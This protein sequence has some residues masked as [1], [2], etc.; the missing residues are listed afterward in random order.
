[1]W[2]LHTAIP[3]LREVEWDKE[4]K[5]Q[6]KKHPLSLKYLLK[7]YDLSYKPSKTKAMIVYSKGNF[8]HHRKQTDKKTTYYINLSLVTEVVGD[9]QNDIDGYV[10]E[11]LAYGFFDK[12]IRK[13]LK[14]DHKSK[15]LFR[16]NENTCIHDHVALKQYEKVF[17]DRA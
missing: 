11:L 15:V 12:C 16:P 10:V 17:S 9:K 4:I 3:D 7:K 8:F 5:F 6:C 14:S 1:M 2:T 13:S